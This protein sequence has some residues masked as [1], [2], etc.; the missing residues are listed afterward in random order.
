MN[1]ISIEAALEQLLQNVSPTQ[2]ET[3]PLLEAGDRILA[4]DVAARRTQPP[5]SA[6]AM[7]GY[8]V[9]ACETNDPNRPLK[10][11]G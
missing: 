5:F 2:Q 9:K 4:Q 8:G 6:S 1:L 3:L 7:D 10:V 11:I